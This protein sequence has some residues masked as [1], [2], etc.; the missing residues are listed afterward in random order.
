[1]TVW[2]GMARSLQAVVWQLR[3]ADKC[4]HANAL[5]CPEEGRGRVDVMELEKS[6]DFLDDWLLT[7]REICS[8]KSPCLS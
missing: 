2:K 5:E 6:I 8:G 3:H 1:M 4:L 7:K